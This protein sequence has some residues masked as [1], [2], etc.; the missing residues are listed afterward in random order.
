MS[1]SSSASSD[2]SNSSDEFLAESLQDF[3]QEIQGYMF[4]PTRTAVDD[5]DSDRFSDSSATTYNARLQ[6]SYW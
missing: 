2:T 6:N 3:G 4:Q 5:L 1:K